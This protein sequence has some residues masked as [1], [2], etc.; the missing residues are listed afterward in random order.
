MHT[1]QLRRDDAGIYH[2]RRNQPHQP[3]FLRG[4]LAFINNHRIGPASL[5]KGEQIILHEFVV[6]NIGRGGNQAI[7]IHL[8]ILPEQNAILVN[9]H[10]IAVGGKLAVN[11]AG[12]IAVYTVKCN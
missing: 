11:L 12:G 4:N 9:N 2:I 6:I 10:H 5:V 7:Y 8:G 1:A 3:S